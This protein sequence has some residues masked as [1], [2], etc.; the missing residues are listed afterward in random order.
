V[1]KGRIANRSG[2]AGRVCGLGRRAFTVLETLLASAIGAVV[3]LV[4][5]GV[6]GSVDRTDRGTS[7]RFAQTEAMARTHLVM[8]R[9]L[10]NLVM[11]ELGGSIVKR[12]TAERHV[13]RP[14]PEAAARADD[15]ERKRP[16]IMLEEDRSLSLQRAIRAAGL[17][18]GKVQRLEVVVSAAPV[19]T[20]MNNSLGRAMIEAAMEPDA[21]AGPT[22]RGVFELRPDGAESGGRNRAAAAPGV[23]PSRVGWTLWWRSLPHDLDRFR[24]ALEMD[25]W[26]DPSAVAVASGLEMCRWT[27]F[28]KRKRAEKFAAGEFQELPA[29]IELEFRTTSGLTA[30]WMFEVGWSNG[31]ETAE[32]LEEAQAALSPDGRTPGA[33]PTPAG[34]RAG[35]EARGRPSAGGEV[36]GLRAGGVGRTTRP[37]PR[38]AGT[39]GEKR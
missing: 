10:S 18:A 9:A 26:D 33:L 6:F 15:P 17:S 16:R 13:A 25:P 34:G 31:P 39:P 11:A 12:A 27:A 38:P 23:D 35:G 5:V 7:L 32:E 28:S 29:F 2:G 19:P 24:R 22:I 4:A 21:K 37:P 20:G 36:R 14:E 8:D 30:N 3:L 1:A